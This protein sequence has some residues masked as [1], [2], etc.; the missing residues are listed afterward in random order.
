MN[1]QALLIYL[2]VQ[3]ITPGPSNFM[4]LY[5]AATYGFAGGRGFRLGSATGFT[6]KM[7]LCGLLNILLATVVPTLVPYLK[8]IGAAYLLYL[9]AHILFSGLKARK[10]QKESENGAGEQ[11]K[12][13]SATFPGGIMLQVLN[14]KSWLM[15]LTAFSVYIV[16]FTTAAKDLLLWSGVMLL[17]M[18]TCTLIWSLFG[19][20]IQRIYA[21]YRLPFDI[22]FALALLY[23]AIMAVL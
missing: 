8:W 22:L 23:S 20:A 14:I 18:Y 5:T 19:S 4:S 13:V 9:A 6:V 1:V 3:G 12:N 16:P 11:K 21:K 2:F 15:G 17:V 7:L 10:S